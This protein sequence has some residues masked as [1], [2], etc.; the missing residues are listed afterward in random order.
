MKNWILAF[1][2]FYHTSFAL[3]QAQQLPNNYRVIV[4][5][6]PEGE[7]TLD[8]ETQEALK[9]AANAV[10]AK[11]IER[12]IKFSIQG[13]EENKLKSGIQIVKDASEV[14]GKS[15]QGIAKNGALN[16]NIFYIPWSEE[17][18][19]MQ[20]LTKELEFA[21]TNLV[22]PLVEQAHSEGNSIFLNPEQDLFANDLDLFY[23]EV[24]SFFR[25]T[26]RDYDI[27]QPMK[28]DEKARLKAFA[29]QAHL[30]GDNVLTQE[31]VLI[32][33]NGYT[34]PVNEVTEQAQVDHFVIPDR[35]T[36]S[37][38]TS[39]KVEPAALIQIES[40]QYEDEE[41]PR[42]S[43]LLVS[44]GVDTG[45]NNVASLDYFGE[46]FDFALSVDEVSGCGDILAPETIKS[47]SLPYLEGKA[48]VNSKLFERVSEVGKLLGLDVAE[49]LLSFKVKIFNMVL[50]LDSEATDLESGI[51]IS[52]VDSAVSLKALQGNAC[53]SI[54]S[55]NDQLTEKFDA[56]LDEAI[57]DGLE[58]SGLNDLNLDSAQLL[59]FLSR[60]MQ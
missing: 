36:V 37:D 59:N 60:V 27:K 40:M 43:P 26:L 44:F 11:M 16:L 21:S 58:S 10:V 13:K 32:S 15:F 54:G 42:V 20:D 33:L 24:A 3:A 47:Q 28:T 29:V 56:K 1:F 50:E 48:Q 46:S 23:F 2:L 57:A 9:T 51:N 25:Y 30:Q 49:S 31:Q 7:V 39:E 19:W 6:Q 45:L 14:A 52:Y 17:L 18:T 41:S 4:T 22:Y 53:F 8:S 34:L 55:V 12:L 35:E 38:L 5:A